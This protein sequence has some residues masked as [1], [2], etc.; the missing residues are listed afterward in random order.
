MKSL[1]AF[2]SFKNEKLINDLRKATLGKSVSGSNRNANDAAG[3]SEEEDLNNFLDSDEEEEM[4]GFGGGNTKYDDD[5]DISEDEFDYQD[6]I[7]GKN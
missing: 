3:Y 4:Y 5:F 1:V 7:R 6:Q 2:E